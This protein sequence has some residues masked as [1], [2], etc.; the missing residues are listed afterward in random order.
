MPDDSTF[1]LRQNMKEKGLQR[2]VGWKKKKKERERNEFRKAT[3]G[4][5]TG[6]NKTIIEVQTEVGNH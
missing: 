1:S 4:N 6:V 5:L 2:D 3:I